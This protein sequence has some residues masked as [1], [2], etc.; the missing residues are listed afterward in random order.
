MH[1]GSRATRQIPQ[2]K[3]VDISEEQLASDCLLPRA[4]NIFKQPA[5]LQAAEVRT[6]RQSGL[7][8]EAVLPALAG[9][10][11]DIFRNP[12]VL[13]NNCICKR[14]AGL[15]LPKDG[16]LPLIGDAACREIRSAQAALLERVRNH[17]F[18]TSQDF[19]RI[20]LH[21]TRL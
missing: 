10:A 12:R 4:R 17:F 8:P 19:Q 1:S 13:P 15:A 2:K 5:K 14:P 3:S 11:R 7:R 18:R 9:E 16:G 21:P 20:M 6:Q